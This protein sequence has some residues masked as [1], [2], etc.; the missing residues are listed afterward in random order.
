MSAAVL[1]FVAATAACLLA[2]CAITISVIRRASGAVDPNV[3]RPKLLVEVI[4]ALVPALVLA[5]VLTATWNRVRENVK[6]ET[7]PVMKIAQ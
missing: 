4:W 1:V 6:T 3:P 2:H 5:F 7:P